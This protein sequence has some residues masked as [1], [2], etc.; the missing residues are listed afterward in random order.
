MA[1]AF[2]LGEHM[3]AELRPAS[4]VVKLSQS[5]SDIAVPRALWVGTAGTATMLDE[6]GNTLTDFPL[7]AGL[8]PIRIKRWSAG[9]ASDVWALY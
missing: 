9:T 3:S 5:G 2:L 7:K 6:Q 4:R 1:P 8:N